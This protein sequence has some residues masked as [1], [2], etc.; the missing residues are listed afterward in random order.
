MWQLS[1]LARQECVRV[2]RCAIERWT[3]S[4][5]GL[6]LVATCAL[7]TNA[8]DTP[9]CLLD[10]LKCLYS[11]KPTSKVILLLESAW[12]PLLVADTG[13][14]L[15]SVAQTESLVRHRLDT[16]YGGGAEDVSK[17]DVRLDWRAGD[18][19]A[20]GYGLPP[21]AKQFLLE[22][23]ERAGIRPDAL[24]P[25]FSWGWRRLRPCQ[26]WSGRTGW[27]LWPEQDRLLV[28]RIERNRLVAIHPSAPVSDTVAAVERLVD[29]ESV[30][31]GA[32]AQREQIIVAAWR[33][34]SRLPHAHGRVVWRSVVG[35]PLGAEALG[36]KTSAVK[37]LS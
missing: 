33:Q 17:W 28:G 22:A 2:G 31:N 29:G 12:L 11:S 3:T 21:R 5:L 23:G 25:A 19:F 35:N 9:D 16:L 14:L 34:A 7:P 4:K 1:R 6:T 27:W 8:V 32:G 10:A 37:E 13:G 36:A 24:M 20:L 18:R 26:T 30:R 15:W